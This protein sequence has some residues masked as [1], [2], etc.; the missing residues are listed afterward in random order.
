MNSNIINTYFQGFAICMKDIEN[1][2][3]FCCRNS[4]P[5][6]IIYQNIFSLPATCY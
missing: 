3:N 5:F 6:N 4:Y 1:M 2:K